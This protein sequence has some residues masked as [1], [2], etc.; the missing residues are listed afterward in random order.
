MFLSGCGSKKQDKVPS[1]IEPVSVNAS[2]RPVEYGSVG[3][4]EVLLGTVVPREYGHYYDTNV[5]ISQITVDMGDNVEEGDVLAYADVD[6]A[7]EEL[8]KYQKELDYEN[9]SYQLNCKISQA[10]QDDYVQQKALAEQQQIAE[11]EEN[12]VADA[13]ND[14]EAAE[15]TIDYNIQLAV[16]QEN[17]R[18]DTLLH[19]YH[20]SNLENSIAKLQKVVADGTLTARK[21]GQVTYV[22]N[23]TNGR[24]AGANENIVVISDLGDT[25]IELTDTNVSEY[26]FTDY[27]KKYILI[28][29]QEVSVTE[30]A[31]STEE[32]ILA[33]VNQK[34][35]NVRIQCPEAGA[36]ILGDNYPVYFMKKD[37]EHVLVVGNDSLNTQ[38][39]KHYVYV[40]SATGEQEKREIE[41]GVAD[42]N[43]TQVTSGLSEGDMVYYHSTA[44]LPYDYSQ[45]EVVLSDFAI[46]NHG[47]RFSKSDTNIFPYLSEYEGTISKIAVTQDTEVKKGD[48]L[49]IID[50]GVGKA[51]MA[52]AENAIQKENE[53]Y[54]QKL[55]SYEEQKNNSNTS[56]LAVLDLQEQLADL[57]HNYNLE[58]LETERDKVGKNNDGTGKI[59]V[60]AQMD[61]TVSKIDVSEES[62]VEKD[63]QVLQLT[64]KSTDVL[65]VQMEQSKEI[66]LY[67]DNIADIGERISMSTK[68]ATYEGTC[69]GQAVSNINQNKGYVYTDAQGKAHLSYST[70]SGY[71]CPAFYIKL[72]NASDLSEISTASSVDFSYR[73]LHGAMVLPTSLIYKETDPLSPNK[74]SYYVW[75][76]MHQ[77]LIKQYVLIDDSL[78]NGGKTVVLSGIVP[79]D[80]L[81]QE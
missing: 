52:E 13:T 14:I 47:I 30:E 9:A 72:D 65:L 46:P 37:T 67:P 60:Y 3:K 28:N 48:L 69:V 50:T 7:K 34:Y 81:A 64:T 12:I 4:K 54:Q 61:G 45:Y 6:A 21:S 42:D 62:Q 76:V 25:Y 20:V 49:Y 68:D 17:A 22:K 77:E 79:G 18:Y 10:K 8:A 41:I 73:L 39:E 16:E 56:Q 29:G 26:K 24:N 23:I 53:S 1:L 44:K 33:E 19:E 31:Y 57:E 36:L 63:D 27:E 58:K 59:S 71:K 15:P 2:Y 66:T 80:I 51:A 43:Y 40:K 11:S 75:R 35:P 32:Q 70:L 55:A 74:V 38:G 5:A 78:Q